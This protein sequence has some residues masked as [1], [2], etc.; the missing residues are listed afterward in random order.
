LRGKEL[1][2][3]GV[4]GGFELRKDTTTLQAQDMEVMQKSFI[5]SHKKSL[6]A[7]GH[8]EML[9]KKLRALCVS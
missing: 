7:V 1:G 5:A 2:V 9:K 3:E 8:G 6:C 4:R